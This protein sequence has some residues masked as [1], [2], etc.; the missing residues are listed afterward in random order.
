[1]LKTKL[2]W[3]VLANFAFL[4]IILTAMTL[5]T[6]YLLA[7]IEKNFGSTSSEIRTLTNVESVRHVLADAPDDA[8]LYL[9]TGEE[10]SKASYENAIKEFDDAIS[11]ADNNMNDSLLI[12]SFAEVRVLTYKWIGEIGDKKIKLGNERKAG[13][14]I[15][16]EMASLAN[17]EVKAQYLTQARLLVREMSKQ[18]SMSQQHSLD[19]AT[20]LGKGLATFIGLVNILL[21]VFAVALGFVLT[22]SITNPVSILKEGTQNIMAGKFDPINLNRS[23]ELGQLAVDFNKMSTMLGNNYTRLNAYSE[24]VTALNAYA[25]IN[26]IQHR[27][28]QLLCH[29]AK[30]TVGALY[31]MN[32]EK[33]ILELSAGYALSEKGM[34]VKVFAMGEGIPGQCAADTTAAPAG[35]GA[36]SKPAIRRNAG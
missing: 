35:A 23:D 17:E 30:A 11:V 18:L 29:H 33:N 13:T 12:S 32:E 22:R 1:M 34:N 28:L 9:I 3:R 2:Y 6:L 26:T 19:R 21:A 8:N 5:L 31:L 20:G 4:L 10:S 14:N 27:S 24:L 36:P 16:A 15:D 25:D 7:E